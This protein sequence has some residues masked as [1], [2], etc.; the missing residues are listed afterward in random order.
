MTVSTP[1]VAAVIVAVTRRLL[2][3]AKVTRLFASVALNFVPLILIDAP[4]SA[5]GADAGLLGGVVVTPVTVGPGGAVA[6]PVVDVGAR[7]TG[8]SAGPR[9][10][11]RTG[12]LVVVPRSGL[13]TVTVLCG[14]V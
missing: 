9:A 6:V 12:P 2:A 5:V 3:R 10:M 11:A 8:A 14:T 7:P 4:V 1:A 13:T